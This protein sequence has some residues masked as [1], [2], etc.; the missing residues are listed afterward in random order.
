[1]RNGILRH[2]HVVCVLLASLLIGTL[3]GAGVAFAHYAFS[4]IADGGSYYPYYHS[5]V[6]L[7]NLYWNYTQD[8]YAYSQDSRTDFY[9]YNMRIT[10]DT[11]ASPRTDYGVHIRYFWIYDED[12]TNWVQY[13]TFFGA[14]IRDLNSTRSISTWSIT[15]LDP[16]ND[17]VVVEIPL[18]DQDDTILS[19]G[20]G[21]QWGYW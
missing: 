17:A 13:S 3:S 2:W 12:L 7:T 10:D 14:D 11:S 15:T 8:H 18:W 19:T 9:I 1:M 4:W 5:D 16:S 21:M 6:S 20:E